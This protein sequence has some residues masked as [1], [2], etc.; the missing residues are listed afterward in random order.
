M[1]TAKFWMGTLLA[2]AL[3]LG[4]GCGSEANK[5]PT[6]QD[7]PQQQYP[8]AGTDAGVLLTLT[9]AQI[10]RVLQVANEGEVMLGQYAAPLATEQAV[11][12]FNNQ[13]VT[14]HTA[15][16]QRLDAVLAAE[17]ITPEDSA[18]S[19]Q[20]QTQVQQIMQILAGPNAPA[21]GAALDQALISAQLG[22]HTQVGFLSDSLLSTQI[23]NP[24]LAQEALTERQGVQQHINTAA[25]I[26]SNLVLPPVT[27]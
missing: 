23:T 22:V 13:M 14:E 10:A 4:Y 5:D 24:A 2:G 1:R 7:A 11:I 21:A 3:A 20:L 26:Q 17:G 6:P 27:P 9:D 25:D 18:L 16:K 12:D 15:V 8:D 19:L